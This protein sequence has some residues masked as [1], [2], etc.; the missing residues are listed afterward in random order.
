ML[1]FDNPFS[2][3]EIF[4]TIV[5]TA[6]INSKPDNSTDFDIEYVRVAKILGSAVEESYVQQGLLITRSAETSITSVSAPKVAV[7]SCPL[8][9]QQAETKGTVLIQNAKDLLNYTK[10]EVQTNN[11]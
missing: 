4:A 8:D 7:Y 10:S 11:H 3:A 1:N 6:C 9:T 5:A 2:N